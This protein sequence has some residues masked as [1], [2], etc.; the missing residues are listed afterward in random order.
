ME[1]SRVDLENSRV[2]LENSRVNLAVRK[3][4]KLSA[5]FR[6]AIAANAAIWYYTYPKENSVKE[7]FKW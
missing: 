5:A 4:T 6:V 2:D 3:W 7:K 1:N